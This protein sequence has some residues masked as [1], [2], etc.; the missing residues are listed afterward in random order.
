ML[1]KRG[2]KI[3]LCWKDIWF[4]GRG[5]L[6]IVP[7]IYIYD[8]WDG[9][10]AFTNESPCKG[11]SKY[12]SAKSGGH[13]T[14]SSLVKLNDPANYWVTSVISEMLGGEVDVYVSK[15]LKSRVKAAGGLENFLH[16]TFL[17]EGVPPS[18]EAVEI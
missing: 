18:V 5:G 12:F 15:K 10:T 17:Q 8:T 9:P 16:E 6:L 1:P 11:A 13:Y 4:R 2:D 7:S 3:E 14:D